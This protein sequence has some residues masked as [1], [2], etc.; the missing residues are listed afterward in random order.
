MGKAGIVLEN[1]Q[2]PT[3]KDEAEEQH[4]K[5]EQQESNNQEDMHSGNED[6]RL[7]PREQRPANNQQK[8]REK[9]TQEG[10]GKESGAKRHKR[11]KRRINHKK[12]EN[13]IYQTHWN[14]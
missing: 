7:T 12:T 6:I 10:R 2:K 3:M 14:N 8:T 9:R 11:Q 1:V 5:Q 4:Q 13:Y